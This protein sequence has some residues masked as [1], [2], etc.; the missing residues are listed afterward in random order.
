MSLESTRDDIMM[1]QARFRS[2]SDL[3]QHYHWPDT[4]NMPRAP[5]GGHTGDFSR[6]SNKNKFCKIFSCVESSDM[7]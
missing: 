5:M 3:F 1:V 2:A 7:V 4:L 6:S